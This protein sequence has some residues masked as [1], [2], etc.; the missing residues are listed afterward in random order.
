MNGTQGDIGLPGKKAPPGYFVNDLKGENFHMNGTQGDIGLP[1]ITGYDHKL[2]RH[3]IEHKLTGPPVFRNHA[4]EHKLAGPPEQKRSGLPKHD[5]NPMFRPLP[6]TV[7][8]R[9]EKKYGEG[10]DVIPIYHIVI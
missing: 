2:G 5:K 6:Q 9:R 10:C 1:G 4:I 8:S 7:T 3:A